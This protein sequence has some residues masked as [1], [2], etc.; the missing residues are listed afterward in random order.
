[1]IKFFPLCDSWPQRQNLFLSKLNPRRR[2]RVLHD[3]EHRGSHRPGNDLKSTLET[4]HRVDQIDMERVEV[5]ELLSHLY[6]P[7]VPDFADLAV[8]NNR[9]HDDLLSDL[10]DLHLREV[11][12][13]LTD[14]LWDQHLIRCLGIY[15]SGGSSR[16][17]IVLKDGRLQVVQV[18]LHDL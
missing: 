11:R 15:R 8:L 5:Y 13:L 16:E 10:L 1:S 12:I 3:P 14:D 2:T 6:E 9:V 17:R 7:L 4:V 18:S